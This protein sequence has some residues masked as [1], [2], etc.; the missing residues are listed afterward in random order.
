MADTNL[1][2]DIAITLVVSATND[3][4]SYARLQTVAVAGKIGFDFDAIEDLRIAVSDLCGTV[5]ACAAPDSELRLD[6]RADAS[7][8]TVT[9]RVPLAEGAQLEPDE[10]SSQ[11]LAV[12]TDSYEYTVADDVVSFR[13]TRATRSGD[14]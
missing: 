11:V 12:V 13:M 4:I 3:H 10:L 7:G 8:L 1:D 9:G 5:I 14:A 6:I 2:A